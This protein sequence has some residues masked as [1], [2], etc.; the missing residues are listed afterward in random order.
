MELH[1]D[2]VTRTYGSKQALTNLSMKLGPGITGLLGPNGAG[3]STL[4]KMLATVE[5]PSS[6]TILWNGLDIAKQPGALRERLGYL[7]Q[8]F[9]VYP[10]MNPVEFLEYMAAM[11]GLAMKPAKR[12]INELLEILNLTDCRRQLLGGFSG[13]MKQRV[14]I[15]QSLLNDPDLLIIDEPTVGLD[16][17]ERSHFKNLLTSISSNKI[18]ILSTHIV[19]D[20]E[21]IAPGIV[22]LSGGHLISHGTPELLI[23]NADR[24]VWSLVFPTSGMQEIQKKYI[25]TS[26]I[27]RSNGINARIVSDERPGPGAVQL[28]PDLEDAY[29]Y[30]VAKSITMG[31]GKGGQLQ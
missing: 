11:K 13:G 31:F 5:K 20:I 19:T 2:N 16:P 4:M 7:P 15:A 12:R 24:K 22:I 21:S 30:A 6:G 26:S 29:L 25:V 10:N 14:G 8:D 17:E 28:T 23:E 27:H 3:K 9:G 1:V 18:I